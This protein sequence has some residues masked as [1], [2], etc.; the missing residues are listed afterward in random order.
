MI[1]PA[2]APYRVGRA[3]F[4][5]A[6]IGVSMMNA[7]HRP[8]CTATNAAAVAW[9]T[10]GGLAGCSFCWIQERPVVSVCAQS[11]SLF[12]SASECGVFAV[13]ESRTPWFAS[14]Y[15]DV[16]STV[17]FRCAVTVASWKEMSN[18]LCPGA[19]SFAHGV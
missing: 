17:F 12:R 16:K 14:K 4:S 5:D 11:C 18:D 9:Y 7:S 13:F 2:I 8:T 19:N 3:F 10:C 1:W 15:D 6:T